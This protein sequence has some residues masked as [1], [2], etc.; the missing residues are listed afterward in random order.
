[1]KPN[2]GHPA[3]EACKLYEGCRT[4]FMES[5]GS[6]KPEIIIVGEAP[7]ATE[8]DPRYGA[9]FVG[10]SGNF[11]R[12]AMKEA[13]VDLNVVRFTNIVRCRPPNNKITKKAINECYNFTVEEIENLKPKQVWLMGNTPLNAIL[14][15]SGITN[16]NGSI[17]EKEGV[18][19]VPLYHPAYILRN[20]NAL[21]E[22]LNGMI[23][24]VDGE[25]KAEEF[26]R[27]FPKTLEEVIDMQRYLQ[28]YEYISFDSETSMLRAFERESMIVSVSFAAGKRSFALPIYHSE[29]WWADDELEMVE[30][31]VRQIILEHSEGLIGQNI[32]FDFMQVN[33]QWDILPRA[34][35]DTMLISH[36]LDSRSGIHGLKRLAG[37][38]LGWYEYER[39]LWDYAFKHPETNPKKGGSFANM[40]LD[41]LLP[42][43]AMDAEATLLLHDILYPKLSDKQKILYDQLIL[44]ASDA[45]THMQCNGI[46]LDRYIAIRYTHIYTIMRDRMHEDIDNDPKVKKITKER[47]AAIDKEIEGTKR[48]RRIFRFNPGSFMQLQ[49]LY[50]DKYKIPVLARTDKNAPSTAGDVY[51]PLEPKY[52]ILHKVRLY[53]L[54]NKMLSTYLTPAAIGAWS[55]SLDGRVRT[56]YNLHGTITG[57]TSSSDPVNLQNIPTPE[58]EPGTLLEILPIKN[59]FTHSYQQVQPDGSVEHDGVI[60]SVD[61]SGMELRCYASLAECEPML[62]IHRSDRDFHTMIGSMV[63]GIKYEAIDKATRYIYKWTNWTLLY[64]GDAWTLHRLYN[65]PIDEAEEAVRKYFDRFPEVLDYQDACVSFA[66]DHGYI[67]SPF[68]RREHLP[69]ILDRNEKRRNKAKREAINMPVQSGAGDTLLAALV[70]VDDKLIEQRLETKAV[71]EVHDSIVLDVPNWEIQTVAE[72]CKDV[73][74]NIMVYAKDYF[75]DLDFSWLKSPLKADVELGTHYGTEIAYEE[76]IENNEIIYERP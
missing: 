9:P 44:Q 19:Y 29:E 15:E 32:K 50:F 43:G 58:K 14:G 46:A 68:G 54:F 16:W 65:I 36:L 10:E 35:G 26:D 52:P 55:S 41:I 51:R 11:L 40:P 20:D 72:M 1:M 27:R 7:G 59:I 66:E 4:P 23:K 12:S 71:N 21:E 48:K 63:S 30:E 56:N 8:D 74:E 42:Y 49:D 38:H 47:Q 3:C 2:E 60:M 28:G 64:G 39:D 69:W 61:Y 6:T 18:T 33:N 45:L 17:I 13:G 76:W 31:I 70:I 34:G 25:E 62:E 73:M 75:P 67:E 37:I 5:S 22:W 57:R 53:K 24:A